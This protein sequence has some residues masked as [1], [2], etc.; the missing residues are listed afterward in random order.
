M[1]KII[2]ISFLFFCIQALSYA[3]TITVTSPNGGESWNSCTAKNI[4]WTASS[5]SG[6]YNIDYSIDNGLTWVGIATS[7]QT[8]AG[9]F[10]W[11]LPNVSSVN[12]L[13]RVTD[14]QSTSTSDISNS[15]FVING[16]L[17]VLSPNGGENFIT[18]T[19]QNIVYSY[20]SGVVNNIKIDYSHDGGLNWNNVISTTPANGSFPWVIPNTPSSTVK[21]RL[22]DLA[23]PTCKMDTS[24]SPFTIT[25]NLT[26]LTPN[27]GETL[28]ATVGSQ[29]S[30]VIMN[31]AP[32]RLNTA[33]FY[34]DGGLGSNYS[35]NSF[36]K[37]LRP[38]FPTNKL[39]IT[40]QSY[41]FETGDILYVYDGLGTS[42]PLLATLSASSSAI[43]N[44]Q[45]TNISGALTFRF[46]SDGDNQQRSGWDAFVTSVGSTTYNL[47]WNIVGT[48][49]FFNIDYSIDNGTNW[50]RVVS[51]Y[52]SLTGT[53]PWQVPNTP[54]AQARVRVQD[55]K[56]NSISDISNNVFTITAASPFFLLTFPD[57]GESLFPSTFYNITWASAFTGQNASLEYSIDN[58][59]SWTTIISSTPNITESYSW[60]VP[61]TPSTQ[62]LVRVK[63][64]ANAS[65]SDV[66]NAVFTI[67]PHITVTAPNGGESG[68]R[69]SAYNI[70]WAAGGTSGSYK[71]EYSSDGGSSWTQIVTNLSNACTGN[72]C[73][74]A[75][76]LP[77]VLTTQLKVR[78]SDVADATKL[79]VSDGNMSVTLPPNP[80]TLLSP[81]GGETWVTG[82]T[83]NITYTYGSG[84]TSVS[85]DYSV[86]NGQNWVSIANNVTANGS[87]AWVVPNTP[88][89]NALVRVTGNQFNG[90]DYDISN[91]VFTIA[92]SV[93]VTAPNGG[94]SWQAM[95]GAQGTSINMSNATVVLNTAN[96]YDNGGLSNNYTSV[97]YVQTLVPD[98]PLNKL[99]VY[100]DSWSFGSRGCCNDRARLVVHNGPTVAGA[101]LGTI[102]G[103]S[104]AGVTITSTDPSG[105]L[106]FEFL[107]S[108]YVGAGW[109]GYVTSVGTTARNITWN[110]I[111]TSKRFDLDYSIDGGTG[112]TRIVSDL[113]NTTGIYGWQVPNT[114]SAQ[115]RVRVRDAGNNAIID[116]SDA[117]FTITAASPVILVGFPNGGE[118]LYSGQS[119]NIEWR[120]ST[121]NVDFVKIEY[122]NDNGISWN[123]VVASTSNNGIYSWVIPEVALPK[124]NCRIRISKVSEPQFFDLSDSVFEI[125]PWIFLTS[126]N[127][128]SSLFQSCTQSSVTWGGN[129]ATSCKIELSIDSGSSW[130]VLNPN[131]SVT[132]FNNNYSWLIPNTPS[133]KCL[134]RVTDNA[135]PTKFDVSDS[136]FT[137]RP[138]LVLNY[139]A[140]GGV[141][142][143]GSEIQ[144]NWTSF[145][146]STFFNL[147]YSIDNGQ[148]WVSI[149]RNLNLPTYTYNWTVP[150]ISSNSVKIR[151]TDFTSSCK[152]TQSANPFSISPNASSVN[153]T[154][155]NSGTYSSC[156]NL[157]LTWNSTGVEKVNL[158][159]SANGGQ[160]W[161][162]I[163]SNI[164]AGLGSYTWVI[165][166]LYTNQ[167]LIKIVD[168]TN[169]SNFDV[170][171]NVFTIN[172]SLSV[173]IL[174]SGVTNL[175][176]GQSVTL[177][178]SLNSGNA[179]SNGST[180]NSILVTK[181]GDYFVTVTQGNCTTRSNSISVI[182]N[183]IPPPP[184]I[185]TN[186]SLNI[187]AGTDL[188]LQSNQVS[189]N[190]WSPGGETT[191]A[192]KVATSGTYMVNYTNSNGC[193]SVS[194]PVTVNVVG[195]ANPPIV[196]GNS[197]VFVGGQIKLTASNIQGATYNWTGPN[198]YTSTVQN[199][200]ISDV[201]MNMAGT[202][203]VVASIN[204]CQTN[205]Q[206]VQI[207]VINSNL[208]GV[209]GYFIHPLG[210]SIPFVNVILS[211]SSQHDT[212]SS[213]KGK[214]ESKGY[215]GGAYTLTPN[216]INEKN[217]TNGVTTLDIISV[218][219]HLLNRDTLNSPYKIIAADVNS[220]NSVTTLD[221]IHIRRLILGLDTVFPGNKL[222]SFI[223]SS[224]TFSSQINPFPYPSSRSYSSLTNLINQNFI[225]VKLGDVT[226]DINQS[227]LRGEN[228]TTLEAPITLYTNTYREGL[229]DTII[230]PI[231]VANFRNI[232][233]IQFG[234]NWDFRLFDLISVDKNVLPFSFNLNTSKLGFATFIWNHPLN[235]GS[236]FAD[237]STI[238]ELKFVKRSKSHFVPKLDLW[239]ETINIE[240][241]DVAIKPY[242]II[243]KQMVNYAPQFTSIE[244]ETVEVFPNPTSG[245][246]F[247]RTRLK[248]AKRSI[249][250]LYSTSGT[251]LYTYNHV[252]N[253]GVDKLEI[254]LT[255]VNSDL[256]SGFYIITINLDGEL[257]NYKILYKK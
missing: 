152:T 6:Y 15:V 161:S 52:Y 245:P 169:P 135:N 36:T 111:G 69:C 64:A 19:S 244:K 196:T 190:S 108:T 41:D 8:N 17:I 241:Y 122:S 160:T 212:L 206:T 236:S 168:V 143:A 228:V 226:W 91:A 97:D 227:Q 133:D 88:S 131:F 99:R 37:T 38:D 27:G 249:V 123:L 175:C 246:L 58:G 216:K 10:I 45:A 178:S 5:T 215:A 78:V 129:I 140:Y 158:Q 240:A 76:T 28:Q 197:P 70:A 53:F 57:G 151:V 218:Q 247:I 254:N 194:S 47:S 156:T 223:P 149:G 193:T 136:V 184:I 128:N 204:G 115:A 11:N 231:K 124:P 141:L 100:F 83:Q 20:I 125:R 22:T 118:V 225:G 66:S 230:L 31:N 202:Y 205:I 98:N 126:P 199:P 106:T 191:Q 181:S 54:T 257:F 30:T 74:Y 251:N 34:D 112:W 222:W 157:N 94:E 33:S 21:V 148:N 195:V 127:G 16:A 239:N 50:I 7:Y 65:A 153:L 171:N 4:T 217:K 39:K 68:P 209:Q 101:I 211:G 104:T 256:K 238:F 113:P 73:T 189:G 192:I 9:S 44:Y 13:V 232:T 201:Q 114:P 81:N 51:N 166:N 252:F 48:S 130:V 29:G 80:V 116:A 172:Q 250:S 103:S 139:P 2:F 3:G 235:L 49:K 229:G 198:G 237:S 210:D 40:F 1:K 23:D 159:F 242:S 89:V 179:W 59:S 220:S 163:A 42:S 46:V 95:V 167:A 144:I 60:L 14:A 155:A 79:D 35:N 219:K 43:T 119:K 24:N 173:N 32:E 86:D 134:V 18:G 72:S 96:Y 120:A 164:L 255:S 208:V 82:T 63:D 77:N 147:D 214:F 176:A 137:I 87:Y 150:N 102:E 233:G 71:L 121:F 75:W 146:T 90:C 84:T 109:K 165:P 110:I 243:F 185:S 62:C 154:S 93:L 248:K 234:L 107:Q 85:L 180:D 187:C 224:H 186:N 145:L 221:I 12:C 132:S 105:A 183:P 188:V 177:T 142:K 67:R 92:S 56:N 25:S 174:T 26:V 61:N 55:A 213:I 170:S 203:G 162:I 117:N 207:N 138:S 253:E 182:V 200:V